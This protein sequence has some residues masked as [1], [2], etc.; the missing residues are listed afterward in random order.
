LD[1]NRRG[2][3]DGVRRSCVQQ[4]L[5]GPVVSEAGERIVLARRDVEGLT[6]PGLKYW[7]ELPIINDVIQQRVPGAERTDGNTG[8]VEVRNKGGHSSRPV[9]DNAIYRL[10]AALTRLASYNFPF[11]LNEVTRAYFAQ[12]AKIET[13]PLASDLAKVAAGDRQAMERVAQQS[14]GMNSMLRATC[15]AT[16][17]EGGHAPNALPQLAAANGQLPNFSGRH[18]G[19]RACNAQAS[20]RR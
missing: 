12:P 17:L 2:G 10:A 16:Q 14:P 7:R 11:Q 6:A 9:P 8:E 19:A 3:A 18:R 4:D 20:S 1:A 5:D 13:G 15:V